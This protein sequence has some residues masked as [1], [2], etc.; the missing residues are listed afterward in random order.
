MKNNFRFT[1]P[2]VTAMVSL[3][4]FSSVWTKTATQDLLDLG[5]REGPTVRFGPVPEMFRSEL[6]GEVVTG[7][8][9]DDHGGD[10]KSSVA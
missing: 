1:N 9:Q 2:I 5:I 7:V 8:F 3:L 4:L 10:G 6:N